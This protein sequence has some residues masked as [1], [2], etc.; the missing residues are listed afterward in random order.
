MLEVLFHYI[1]LQ[2]IEVGE[3]QQKQEIMR[4]TKTFSLDQIHISF[5]LIFYM[6]EI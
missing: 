4:A 5:Y 3:K 2:R 6:T 1:K